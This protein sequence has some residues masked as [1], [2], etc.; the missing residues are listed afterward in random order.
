VPIGAWLWRRCYHA[1]P[2]SVNLPS[3]P[4]GLLASRPPALLPSSSHDPAG[5]LN[6]GP[7]S[8]CGHWATSSVGAALAGMPRSIRML[9]PR[10]LGFPRSALPVEGSNA[11]G[12]AHPRVIPPKAAI[13]ESSLPSTAARRTPRLPPSRGR[14]TRPTPTPRC[15]AQIQGPPL[16]TRAPFD[17]YKL[18]PSTPLHP[19]PP[20]ALYP[21]TGAQGSRVPSPAHTQGAPER[22]PEGVR[23][24]GRSEA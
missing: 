14:R 10:S 21:S 8:G 1:D 15:R 23:A 18:R 17:L 9:S 12:D 19:L 3:W 20:F 6:P 22:V 11:L 16:W 24:A 5:D 7:V 2:S 4:P 13:Q